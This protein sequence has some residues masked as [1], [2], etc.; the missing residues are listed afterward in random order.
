MKRRDLITL[1]GGAAA[2][3]YVSWPLAA[4]ADPPAVMPVIGYLGAQ[5]QEQAAERL[6]AFQ[7]GLGETGHVAG[8]N[9]TIEYRWAQGHDDRLPALAADLARRQVAVIAAPGSLPAARAAKAAT[10]SIPIV[11]EVKGE[12]VD[13]GLLRSLSEPDGNLTGVTSV[14]PG[15]RRLELL[16]ELVPAATRIGAVINPAS[17]GAGTEWR[18]VQVAARAL[19]VRLQGLQA[20]TERDFDPMIVTLA[21]VRAGGLVICADPFFIEQSEQLAAMTV[22]HA[23][24]AIHP[25]RRFAAAGGLVSYDGSPVVSHRLV[26]VYVGRI[27]KGEKPADLPVQQAAKGE[28]VVNLKTAK[29]LGL[30]VPPTLLERAE[31]IE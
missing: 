15:A 21:R 9:V 19:G 24:P 26:G 17:P 5:S 12:P 22:R 13:A 4:R 2:A 11:F 8:Q 6:R 27:L 14:E 23:L 29:A 7:E 28:L 10:S 20:T 16:R 30:A 1:L 18:Q 31:V 25:S 3:S